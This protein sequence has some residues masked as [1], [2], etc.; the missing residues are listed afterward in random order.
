[1]WLEATTGEGE[2]EI[3]VRDEGEG[4]SEETQRQPPPECLRRGSVGSRDE[5]PSSIRR[6]SDNNGDH[7]ADHFYFFPVLP[8]PAGGR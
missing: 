1:V 3:A 7:A 8:S 2:L 6:K 5:K 4:M